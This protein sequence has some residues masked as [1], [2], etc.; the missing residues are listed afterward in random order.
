MGVNKCFSSSWLIITHEPLERTAS[1]LIWEL[2]KTMGLFLLGLK[3]SKCVGWLLQRKLNFQAK[4]G[5]QSIFNIGGSL[6]ITLTVPLRNENLWAKKWKKGKKKEK[7]FWRKYQ[8]FSRLQGYLKYLYNK[9][10][11]LYIYVA[12]SRPNGGTEWAKIVCGHSWVAGDV[13]GFFP[14]AASVSI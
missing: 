2:S 13:L 7:N 8:Y 14:R 5:F 3:V 4:I 9:T 6:E 11:H 1:N 12:Y 10:R